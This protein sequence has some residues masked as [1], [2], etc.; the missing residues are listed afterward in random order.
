MHNTTTSVFDAIADIA[1]LPTKLFPL[2]AIHYLPRFRYSLGWTTTVRKGMLVRIAC[3][4]IV[5]VTDELSPTHVIIEC[6]GTL[7]D[8]QFEIDCE[9]IGGDKMITIK[10]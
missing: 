7:Y 5:D 1:V 3:D 9:V 6:R 10:L 8:S 2:A 4:T